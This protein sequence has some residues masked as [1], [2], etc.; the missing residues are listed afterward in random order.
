MFSV[1]SL[2]CKDFILIIRLNQ[3]QLEPCPKNWNKTKDGQWL[4][5]KSGTYKW[6]EIQDSVDY[7]NLFEQPKIIYQVIQT[8]PL[9]SF[10]DAGLYGNDKTFILPT[11][12]LSLLSFLNSPLLWWYGNRIFTRMLSDSISPMGYLFETLPIV[13]TNQKTRSEM[14]ELT[15]QLIELTKANQQTYRDISDW[16]KSEQNIDK[17]GQKLEKFNQLS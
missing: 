12:S 13:D 3:C 15:S 11:S 17:L 14:E 8:S 16:L 7:W 2:S 10:D 1:K 9:Y 5:R 4:G 6:Y